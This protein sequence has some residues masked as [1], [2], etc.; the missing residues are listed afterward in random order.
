MYDARAVAQYIVDR[1]NLEGKGVSNLKLQKILYF[2]QAQFLVSTPDH[3]PCFFNLIE[4]W[5][6]GPVVPD[7]YHYF[8]IYGSAIIPSNPDN[9]YKPSYADISEEDRH[10]I[11]LMIRATENRSANELVEITHHQT[12]W[13]TAYVPGHSNII[14]NSS[15]RSFFEG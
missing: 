5:D 9:S 6:Y 3:R 8:K 4:A 11:D 1:C 10:L 14:T 12:P 2:V 13:R 7:V 15:I